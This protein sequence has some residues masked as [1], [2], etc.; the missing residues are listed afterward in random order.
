VAHREHV[1]RA[2][3]QCDDRRLVE[4]DAVAARVRERVRGTEVDRE[5][6]RQENASQSD[7]RRAVGSGA[8]A[9]SPRSNSPMLCSIDEGRRLRR[10]T[11]VIPITLAITA[12]NKK[13]T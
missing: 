9:R 6:A 1:L 10:S 11:T 8:R 7:R 5:V 4:D 3:V 12:N 13:A 2:A